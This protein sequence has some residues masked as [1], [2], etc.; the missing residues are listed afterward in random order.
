M[1][2]MESF[3]T[4]TIDSTNQPQRWTMDSIP[5]LNDSPFLEDINSL[6][7]LPPKKLKN[8]EKLAESVQEK[9]ND[10]KYGKNLLQRVENLENEVKFL[11][12]LILKI[13]TDARKA[14]FFSQ[15]PR[16]K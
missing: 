6:K 15:Q 11:H 3:A 4:L 5:N 8:Y 16:K 2:S 13:Q 14:L 10:L 12:N 9:A 1:Q 7:K